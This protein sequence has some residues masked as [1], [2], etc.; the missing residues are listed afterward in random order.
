[1]IYQINS[2]LDNRVMNNT[3]SKKQFN[4]KDSLERFN[5]SEFKPYKID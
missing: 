1:M 3:Q 4:S 5:K 2:F